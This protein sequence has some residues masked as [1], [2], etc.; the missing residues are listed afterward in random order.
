MYLA[1]L[2]QDQEF[3]ISTILVGPCRSAKQ[4]IPAP[5]EMRHFASL[6]PVTG[7]LYSSAMP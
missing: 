1:F 7:Y 4:S 5:A 3:D 6:D 2:V